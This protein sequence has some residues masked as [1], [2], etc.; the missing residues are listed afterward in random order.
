MAPSLTERDVDMLI[1]SLGLARG[2]LKMTAFRCV[3]SVILIFSD[4][5]YYCII[6]AAADY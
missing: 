3:V 5:T 6:I 4:D 1:Q 2:S